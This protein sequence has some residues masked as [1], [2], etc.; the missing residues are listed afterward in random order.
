MALSNFDEKF[1]NINTET[2][3]SNGWTTYN[4]YIN[5]SDT[6]TSMLK[7]IFGNEEANLKGDAFIGDIVVDEIEEANF[8]ETPNS[9]TLVLKSTTKNDDNDNNKDENSNKTKNSNNTAWI[10]A[11]PS[12]LTGAAIVLAIV[13]VALRKVK[14]KKPVKKTKNAYDRNS[15]QSQQ[16]Y[17]RKATMLR[18]E[19]LRELQQQLE[20]LQNERATYETQYKKDLSSLRQ[21]KI[22]RAP[23]SEIA[24]LEKDMK[25]NQK[26]SAQI[27]SSIRSV[28]LEIDFTNSNEY[29][30][31]VVKKLSSAKQDEQKQDNQ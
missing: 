1:S 23:A 22:K 31:Q 20:T 5:S 27:G 2:E 28:E 3:N 16:I 26:H 9:T 15:K 6:T 19:R 11:I 12:I 29:I 14:F 25:Q 24:K 4:F 7:L 8:V 13:G 17:M 10:I 18:E 21:L 30:K